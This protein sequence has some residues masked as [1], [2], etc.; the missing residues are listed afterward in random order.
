MRDLG[1]QFASPRARARRSPLRAGLA[2][3]IVG[4]LVLVL[5][6][7][8]ASADTRNVSSSGT[9]RF[10]PSKLGVDGIQAPEIRGGEEEGDAPAPFDGRITDRRHSRGRGPGGEGPGNDRDRNNAQL[11]T[12]F[13]GLRHRDQRL[14]NNGN[15]FSLEPPDQGLC[16]GNGREVEAVNDVLKVYDQGGGTVVDTTDL[17]T[18]FGYPAQI[19]RTPDAANPFGPFVTD[20]SCLF[21]AATQRWFLTVLTLDVFPDTGEFTGRNTIDIAVSNSP[22]P[23]GTWTI[24]HMPVQDDGTEGTP[25]HNC[26]PADAPDPDEVHAPLNPTACLGDYPHIGADANGFYVTTNEYDFFGDEFHA[27]QVYAFSKRALAAGSSTLAVTQIDTVGADRG[28]PGFTIWP[29]TSPSPAQ[30]ATAQGGT[31]YF[32][33]SNAA[34]EANGGGT[35]R[36]L[37]VWSLTNS[38]SLD[39]AAPAVTLAHRVL[40]VGR[41]GTP[42]P[43]DQKPGPIPLADCI[44]DTTTEVLPGVLGCW[45]LLVDAEPAHDETEY[46]LDSNDTRMQQVVFAGGRL[47]GALDTA[48]TMRGQDKAGIEYFVVRPDQARAQRALDRNGYVGLPQNNLTYPAIGVLP[49][50]RG[51]MAFTV[52]GADHYPSAGYAPIDAR[53]GVGAIHV[54]AEGLGPADG[55]SG[56]KAFGDPPRPRWGDYGAAVPDGSSIW[57]ASEYIG[58]TCTL[59]EYL[60]PPIGSCGGT[61]TALANWYT[62]ISR[63]TP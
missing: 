23:A 40:R 18:F 14:A 54:A 2:G 36:D 58:Q 38:R 10:V 50:G 44:N 63:L 3:A 27:A 39:S 35:S 55:F 41:Y 1:F 29:A 47:Y 9:A 7:A 30:F 15:Q 17:N 53:N 26:N 62:R 21:D 24:Y 22:D 12:S 19:D 61:R 57:I 11:V 42:P 31:E 43:S 28:N 25:D 46:A 6:A 59:T 13:D 4:A 33:S 52:V 8:S 16:A 48:L 49:N 32:L 37:L 20:P 45:Q 5:G 60:T 34:D 56:Y 51:V